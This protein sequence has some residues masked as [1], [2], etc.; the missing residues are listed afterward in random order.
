M[1]QDKPDVHNS[2]RK[3]DLFE[4]YNQIKPVE[5]EE[6]AQ[7]HASAEAGPGA[8]KSRTEREAA[9][10]QLSLWFDYSSKPWLKFVACVV[11]AAFLHQDIVWAAGPGFTNDIKQML[12]QPAQKTMDRLGSLFS[13]KNAYA[14]DYLPPLEMPDEPLLLWDGPG[15]DPRLS[16]LQPMIDYYDHGIGEDPFANDFSNYSDAWD[17]SAY[18]PLDNFKLQDVVLPDIN[19]MGPVSQN[20]HSY[21]P[22][23]SYGVGSSNNS[24]GTG[25]AGLGVGDQDWADKTLQ[26]YSSD[27]TITSPT[28]YD[29]T[30]PLATDNNYSSNSEPYKWNPNPIESAGSWLGNNWDQN[31]KLTSV[32]NAGK[33]AVDWLGTAQTLNEFVE[34]G[35]PET[36]GA[37]GSMGNLQNISRETLVSEAWKNGKANYSLPT[38]KLGDELLKASGWNNMPMGEFRQKVTPFVFGY[39][40]ERAQANKLDFAPQESYERD[41]YAPQNYGIGKVR[42]APTNE[43]V[44]AANTG[45]FGDFHERLGGSKELGRLARM[46]AAQAGL[47]ELDEGTTGDWWVPWGGEKT[48][49]DWN[50]TD[51]TIDI[52]ISDQVKN[53]T[54]RVDQSFDVTAINGTRGRDLGSVILLENQAYVIT[55]PGAGLN[56]YGLYD[57]I[58]GDTSS[59]FTVMRNGSIGPTFRKEWDSSQFRTIEIRDKN[60][61][62]QVTFS[63]DVWVGRTND[64]VTSIGSPQ[65]HNAGYYINNLPGTIESEAIENRRSWWSLGLIGQPVVVDQDASSATVSIGLENLRDDFLNPQVRLQRELTPTPEASGYPGLAGVTISTVTKTSGLPKHLKETPYSFAVTQDQGRNFITNHA[66]ATAGTDRGQEQP[67]QPKTMFDFMPEYRHASTIIN[68]PRGF[69]VLRAEQFTIDN[70]ITV[71]PQIVQTGRLLENTKT[72]N[73]ISPDAHIS[74]AP[75]SKFYAKYADATT[76][77]DRAK[78]LRKGTGLSI[79]TPDLNNQNLTKAMFFIGKDAA[80]G[81][82]AVGLKGNIDYSVAMGEKTGTVHLDLSNKKWTYLPLTAAGPDG[83]RLLNEAEILNS[84]NF[85]ASKSFAKIDELTVPGQNF[86]TAGNN[87]GFKIPDEITFKQNPLSVPPSAADSG[88]VDPFAYQFDTGSKVWGEYFDEQYHIT[89][90]GAQDVLGLHFAVSEGRYLGENALGEGTQWSGGTRNQ[91]LIG[92]ELVRNIPGAEIR[93]GR[94]DLEI[95]S[96]DKWTF[97]ADSNNHIL[98]FHV[99]DIKGQDIETAVSGI[100]KG[101]LATRVSLGR[102]FTPGTEQVLSPTQP[103]APGYEDFTST[104]DGALFSVSAT[105]R[106]LAEIDNIWS[107]G[108][109]WGLIASVNDAANTYTFKSGII[110]QAEALTSFMPSFLESAA[111]QSNLASATQQNSVKFANDTFTLFS[112]DSSF[113]QPGLVKL[114]QGT[115]L[116]IQV[117]TDDLGRYTAS[118]LA[119]VAGTNLVAGPNTTIGKTKII[120]GE[121]VSRMVTDHQNNFVRS[122]DRTTDGVLIQSP[123][124]FFANAINHQLDN[125][126]TYKAKG[127]LLADPIFRFGSIT[128]PTTNTTTRD[129]DLALDLVDQWGADKSNYIISQQ[130]TEP[131]QRLSGFKRFDVATATNQVLD[132]EGNPA[133]GLDQE[134]KILQAHFAEG[135]FDGINELKDSSNTRVL[136]PDNPNKGLEMSPTG[137]DYTQHFDIAPGGNLAVDLDLM[138]QTINPQINL[139]NAEVTFKGT[140]LA[141]NTPDSYIAIGQ[142]RFLGDGTGLE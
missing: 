56:T 120:S 116:P 69:D 142:G 2:Y 135:S 129:W 92:N 3:H 87:I 137:S 125:G 86:I 104:A 4:G 101:H 18:A 50:G 48:Y 30:K 10:G 68:D 70:G 99:R 79:T 110:H 126:I 39:L 19:S 34:H 112:R 82:A 59:E 14:Q 123:K 85:D 109:Q 105:D 133:P 89:T 51:V 28:Y 71:E 54:Y 1:E 49:K 62:K 65:S 118:S 24:T 27:P 52:S 22:Q 96:R 111:D 141:S 60:S 73:F 121:L 53:G 33:A 113:Q 12:Q 58:S 63:G 78:R 127:K 106:Y 128:D 26:K 25:I 16:N 119:G 41:L 31:N 130:G 117:G 140:S 66:T 29:W 46:K 91:M 97:L 114:T 57:S 107:Q 124:D 5:P 77:Y 103:A 7:A 36:I 131:I 84:A 35:T 72:N 93:G 61:H 74:Y 115:N 45:R 21:R 138:N 134:Q 108:A 11:I 15:P 55:N 40:E 67:P 9:Y 13:I 90:P 98:P 80:A 75:G 47:L 43:I 20:D 83:L 32:L 37:L 42:Y 100:N 122:F 8:K 64:K 23:D 102:R 6:I 17:S 136:F 94:F 95:D 81:A 139:T 76:P 38:Q 44:S 88:T 132:L